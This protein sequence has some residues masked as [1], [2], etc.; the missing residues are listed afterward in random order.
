M[1]SIMTGLARYG[2]LAVIECCR[3]PGSSHGRVAGF[4]IV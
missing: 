4:A 3:R 2:R 1:G